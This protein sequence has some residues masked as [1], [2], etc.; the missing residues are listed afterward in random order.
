VLGNA[1]TNAEDKVRDEE[2]RGSVT[3]ALKSDEALE[4]SLITVTVEEGI[5]TLVGGVDSETKKRHAEAI[6]L[7]VEGVEAVVNELEVEL[8][9]SDQRADEEIARAAMLAVELSVR[10]G[11][12]VSVDSGWVTVEGTVQA[13]E[14]KESAARAVS[15]VLGVRGVTNLIEVRERQPSP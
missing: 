4:A 5:V 6:A 8:P 10:G 13:Y 1:P 14:E 2:I 15:R 7:N 9:I 11:V 3:L 12:K